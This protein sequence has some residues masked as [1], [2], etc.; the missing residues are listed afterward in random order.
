MGCEHG[1][2]AYPDG[3]LICAGGRELRCSGGA[4]RETGYSCVAAAGE[5]PDDASHIRI[6]PDGMRV[7]RIT[8]D[9]IGADAY[10]EQSPCVRFILPPVWGIQRLYNACGESR[11][12]TIAWVDGTLESVRVEAHGHTDVH[13]T[14]AAGQIV[15]ERPC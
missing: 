2:V 11:M 6:S 1:G 8:R 7:A 5:R 15:G 9:E 3:A 14:S 10:V 4:W 12:V 13:S